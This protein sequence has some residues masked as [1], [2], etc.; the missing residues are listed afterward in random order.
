[1]SAELNLTFT[2][3]EIFNSW[4]LDW[5]EYKSPK[6]LPVNKYP[7][8]DLLNVDPKNDDDILEFVNKWGL[9]GLGLRYQEELPES[10]LET[11]ADVFIFNRNIFFDKSHQS[12]IVPYYNFQMG[13]NNSTLNDNFD[14]SKAKEWV[15]VSAG[16][17]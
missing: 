12:S 10:K 15:C 5:R 16:K 9:L 8:I 2:P 1:M 13:S 11:Y 14:L 17:W 7:H 6:D 4:N 3:Y